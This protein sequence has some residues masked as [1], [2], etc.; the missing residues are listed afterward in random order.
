MERDIDPHPLGAC[1][2]KRYQERR[3]QQT[4]RRDAVPAMSGDGV[5]LDFY[6]RFSEVLGLFSRGYSPDADLRV[7]LRGRPGDQVTAMCLERL[8]TAAA[9]RPPMKFSA[10]RLD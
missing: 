3:F 4:F 1:C 5:D 9:S 7:L 6:R 2:I 8:H 10:G